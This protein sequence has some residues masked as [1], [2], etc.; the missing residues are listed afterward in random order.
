MEKLIY[1]F[2]R[3]DE[4]PVRLRERFVS[5][6]EPKLLAL[7]VE[8]LQL[9]VADLGDLSDA[10]EHLRLS[11]GDATKPDGFVSFWLSSA[12]RR[13][14]A[15]RLIAGAFAR[16]AGYSVV[17]S[18]VLPNVA[19]PP[20]AG[21]RTY[22]FSQVTFLQVPPRLTYEE[23]RNIWANDHTRIGVETQANFRYVQ[24]VVVQALTPDAPPWRGIV[25]ESFPPEALRDL[26]VFYDA[27]GDEARLQRH[28]EQMMASCA[29]FI[30]F[31]RVDVIATSEYVRQP[32][33]EP[34]L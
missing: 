5:E 27:V 7:G 34:R 20:R 33:P 12:W 22:G 16:I 8:R 13:E 14:P 4:D 17:E 31:D 30:D 11:S 10:V 6:V 9:N 24:N 26:H 25:E 21:E 32:Q 2:W 29:R 1:V 28:L 18:T 3:G 15:E 23:W 19:H